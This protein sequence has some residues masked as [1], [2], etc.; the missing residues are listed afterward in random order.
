[1]SDLTAP[2]PAQQHVT[3]RDARGPHGRDDH[4]LAVPNG[5]QHA[6]PAGTEA[7]AQ[8]LGQ[9]PVDDGGEV[10]RGRHWI[11]ERDIGPN[12]RVLDRENTYFPGKVAPAS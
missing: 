7:H 8:A 11:R 3:R 4:A 5:R 9:Q 1:V 2:G 10:R 12:L 6:A